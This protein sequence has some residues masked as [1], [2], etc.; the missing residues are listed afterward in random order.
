MSRSSIKC[1]I[2]A[3]FNQDFN[4]DGLCTNMTG[5]LWADK[6]PQKLQSVSTNVTL[7]VGGLDPECRQK[8][9]LTLM[10]VMELLW[11]TVQKLWRIMRRTTTCAINQETTGLW[12]WIC[13][14]DEEEP[15]E[16]ME[17]GWGVSRQEN[18]NIGEWARHDNWKEQ[19]I[20]AWFYTSTRCKTTYLWWHHFGRLC[21]TECLYPTELSI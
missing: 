13:P 3:T 11:Q 2:Y 9:N 8:K 18:G 20:K 4:K 5:V 16:Y 17:Q 10:W 19:K 6:F 21:L 12:N 1:S 15:T 14:A 7:P